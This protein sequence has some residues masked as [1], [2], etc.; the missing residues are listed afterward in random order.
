MRATALI[1]MLILTG[2]QKRTP[3]DEYVLI[4][5]AA[6]LE[7]DYQRLSPESGKDDK[8]REK[9]RLPEK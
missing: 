3:S 7:E 9:Q 1:L 8:T 4:E 6:R 5:F 2:C